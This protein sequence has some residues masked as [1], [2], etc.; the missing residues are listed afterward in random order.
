MQFQNAA[1]ALLAG[2]IFVLAFLVGWIYWQQTRIHQSLNTLA[3]VLSEMQP[4]YEPPVEEEEKEKE[5][6]DDREEVEQAPPT[7]TVSGPP[8]DTDDIQSKT[9]KELQE[10]LTKKGI[11]FSKTDSKTVLLQLL[12]AVA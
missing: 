6:E 11:P 7:E 1:I 10:L 4:V 5:E 12:K 9:R 2:M 3:M 8:V